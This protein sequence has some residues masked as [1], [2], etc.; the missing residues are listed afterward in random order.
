M[1]KLSGKEFQIGLAMSGAISA[2]AY[3]S[4]VL[5]FL[6]EALDEW[7]K[8]RGGPDATATPNHRVGLKVMSGAS[9]GAITAA[10][11]AVALADA[12]QRP[13]SHGEDG[14]TFKYHLPK[15]Y[16]TWVVKPGLVAEDGETADFLQTDDLDERPSDA[17]DFSRT[18]GIPDPPEGS[19]LPVTSL[20]NSRLLDHIAKAGIAVASVRNEN[21][22]DKDRHPRAY[23][24][25]TLHIYLTLSNLRGV[26]Y[27]IPFDGGDFHMISH[28]DRVHYQVNGAGIWDTVSLFADADKPRVI[29][30]AWLA[31]GEP[32]KHEWKDYSIC[33]L[34]SAAFPVGLAPRDIGAT[35]GEVATLNEYDGRRFPIEGINDDAKIKPNWPPAVLATPP[36]WFRTADGGIIDNDPFEYARFALKEDPAGSNEPDLEKADRAVIMIS[37]FPEAKPIRA[38][39]Q[40]ASDIL[41]IFSALMP[42]LIDQARF[43]P[44][45]LV[46]AADSNYGS[47][48]LIGPS[49]VIERRDAQGHVMKDQNGKIL[50]KDHAERY[51]IAS[52][53]LGG[54]GGFV[55]RSFR[56][57]DFQLG[58]RN[59]QYFLKQTF[60]LPLKN[61]IVA[62]WESHVAKDNFATLWTEEERR[63]NKP[64][65]YVLIPL[66]GTAADEVVLPKWP[67]ISQARFETLLTRIAQ[68]FD[69]VAPALLDEKVN[70]GVLRRLIQLAWV[71]T[72]SRDNILEFV[73][74]T[75]LTD[76]V[77]RNQIEG[78]DVGDLP[79]RIGMDGDDI[80]AVFAE[81]V[82]PAYDLRTI[83]GLFKAASELATNGSTGP[84]DAAT[85]VTEAKVAKLLE[86]LKAAKGKP[87]EVWEAPWKDKGT[88]DTPPG[89]LYALASRRPPWYRRLFGGAHSGAFF[90]KP[91]VDPP[92]V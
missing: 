71:T 60:A 27:R 69:R 12:D 31:N 88:K 55:A 61:P 53:L 49:R 28:G 86:A 73:R 50:W 75:I 21:D 58:R 54:F 85:K 35:L 70:G 18:T 68:R 41:S 22:S 11:G 37:P 90:S 74:L 1:H 20:L 82:D 7:E 56:D 65:S 9:A 19:P 26:P 30:T 8:A 43:K 32:D 77:R 66:L 83:K 48:Y 14:Q 89:T 23:V 81:L 63:R 59:C 87:Y 47:R 24:S 29:E 25:R 52:G 57:H 6:I 3:T 42:S 72:R 33:A 51:G 64:K 78:W 79:V 92:G 44:S 16:E 5:D 17:D 2:G 38:D 4:G 39:G 13:G 45:E 15:L 40:P 80:R 67:Q 34:A 36:F 62:S 91:R 46:R 84:A 10:I 76:L